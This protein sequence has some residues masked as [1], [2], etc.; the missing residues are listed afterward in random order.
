MILG[1][2]LFGVFSGVS[3]S[4]CDIPWNVLICLLFLSALRPSFR[5]QCISDFVW[6]SLQPRCSHKS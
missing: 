5:G 4:Q 3:L 2:L 6:P 1:V